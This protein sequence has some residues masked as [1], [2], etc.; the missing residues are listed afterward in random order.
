MR[1]LHQPL[2]AALGEDP[3]PLLFGERMLNIMVEGK[4]RRSDRPGQLNP[5]GYPYCFGVASHTVSQHP[6]KRRLVDL[7]RVL[8]ASPCCLKI[9]GVHFNPD[10]PVAG[11]TFAVNR[12]REHDA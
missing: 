6:G 11:A 10:P 1:A 3:V 7:I 5:A 2:E 8:P 4:L 12:D 9:R